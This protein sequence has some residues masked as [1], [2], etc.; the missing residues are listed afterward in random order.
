MDVSKANENKCNLM[1]VHK[2]TPKITNN[3]LKI[4]S[5]LATIIGKE[6]FRVGKRL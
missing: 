1:N 4:Y 5:F 6:I 3:L 2:Q